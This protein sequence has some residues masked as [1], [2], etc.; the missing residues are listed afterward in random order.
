M[1]QASERR[2]VVG[3]AL[4]HAYYTSPESAI[5]LGP[6]WG[7]PDPKNIERVSQELLGSMNPEIRA[8]GLMLE[9]ALDRGLRDPDPIKWRDLALSMYESQVNLVDYMYR[10]R[11]FMY[12]ENDIEKKKMLSRMCDGFQRWQA[13]VGEAL[14]NLRDANWTEAKIDIEKAYSLSQSET[15]TH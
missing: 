5:K 15:S 7:N 4:H 8:I 6:L 10:M 1:L 2:V 3:L 13:S 12:E 11:E 9:Q 14:G